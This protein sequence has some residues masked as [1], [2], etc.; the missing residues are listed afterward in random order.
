VV[1]RL[2]LAALDL[3]IFPLSRGRRR[4]QAPST[5]CENARGPTP[6]NRPSRAGAVKVKA[7]ARLDHAEHDGS[8]MQEMN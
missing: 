6:K 2:A 1:P 7:K 3:Y 4:R 8:C 5:I